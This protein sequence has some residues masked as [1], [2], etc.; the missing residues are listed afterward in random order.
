MSL[1]DPGTAGCI[2]ASDPNPIWG[3]AAAVRRTASIVQEIGPIKRTPDTQPQTTPKFLTEYNVPR[4]C[5]IV[6]Q[7]ARYI[8]TYVVGP[9]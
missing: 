2:A 8:A 5:G 7:V 4:T 3:S 6:H 9:A 1:S